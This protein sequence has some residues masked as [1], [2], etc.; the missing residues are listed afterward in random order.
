M[1]GRKIIQRKLETMN[2][3]KILMHFQKELIGDFEPWNH[4]APNLTSFHRHQNEYFLAE[5]ALMAFNIP[6]FK[7]NPPKEFEALYERYPYM[8]SFQCTMSYPDK[9]RLVKFLDM[10]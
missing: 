3:S 9:I 8:K 10:S 7:Y 4:L 2:T 6:M 5:V 1:N